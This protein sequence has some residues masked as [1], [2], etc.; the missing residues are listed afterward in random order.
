M[1]APTL[2][3]LN[4]KTHDQAAPEDLTKD[5]RRFVAA[6]GDISSNVLLLPESTGLELRGHGRSEKIPLSGGIFEVQRGTWNNKQVAFKT[7]RFQSAQDL[8][9]GK[10]ILWKLLP[11]WKRL[12]HENVLSFHA[13]DTSMSQLVLIYDWDH[14]GNIMQYLKYSPNA[15][16]SELV[17]VGLHLV[18]S[19]FSDQSLKL[20]QV[21]KGLQY[22][23][24]LEI[25]HGNLKGVSGPVSLQIHV[26]LTDFI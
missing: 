13:A 9:K 6:L 26:E 11:I 12:V 20:L 2:I 3:P 1:L 17:S 7:I 25:I 18:H 14:H 21:A 8:K 4:P 10:K 19:A 5:T 24:S 15:S 23:H 22:L 16:R